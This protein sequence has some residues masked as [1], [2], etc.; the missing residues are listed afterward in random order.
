MY[1][2][3][4]AQCQHCGWIYDLDQFE[5]PNSNIGFNE[6]S[7]KEYKKAYEEKIKEN[8]NYDYFEEHKSP[9]KPHNCPVCGEYEFEDE[10]SYDICPVC[11]WEDDDFFEGGGAND[12]SLDEAKNFFSTKKKR[13]P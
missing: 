4:K 11:G 8:P 3:G 9:S 2:S 13:K 10:C 1:S 7:L 5:N 12:M 6:K